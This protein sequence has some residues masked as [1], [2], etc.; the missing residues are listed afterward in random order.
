[1][2]IKNKDSFLKNRFSMLNGFGEGQNLSGWFCSSHFFV[3][4]VNKKRTRLNKDRKRFYF[5]LFV[6]LIHNWKKKQDYFVLT[7]SIYILLTKSVMILRS[8]R[9]CLSKI[10]I[11]S[12]M[13]RFFSFHL[14][15]EKTD[16]KVLV[17]RVEPMDC[18]TWLGDR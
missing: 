9:Y 8:C 17:S 1:M 10:L 14:I 4:S 11:L 6:L 12:K 7:P 16:E 13:L 3:L 18:F 15:Q 2:C 5:S